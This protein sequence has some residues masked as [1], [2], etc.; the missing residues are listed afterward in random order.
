MLL[1]DPAPQSYY[2]QGIKALHDHWAGHAENHRRA[3]IENLLRQVASMVN[4][5]MPQVVWKDSGSS[6][7]RIAQWEI[8]ASL[9]SVT[10]NPETDFK[11]WLHKVTSPYHELRHADQHRVLLEAYLT[12]ALALPVP[13]TRGT[14]VG[15]HLPSAFQREEYPYPQHI[16]M[17]IRTQKQEFQQAWIPQARSWSDSIYGAHSRFRRDT[18]ETLMTKGKEHHYGTY[19]SLPEEADAFAVQTE[20]KRRIKSLIRLADE[21]L[22]LADLFG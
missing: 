14:A 15:G 13:F 8:H 10:T 18:M 6:F 11:E 22:Q 3:A 17:M 5:P 1:D 2:A 16:I 20:V 4:L 9:M 19:R 12:K 7:F 21:D